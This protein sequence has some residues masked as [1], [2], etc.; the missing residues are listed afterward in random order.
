M[1]LHTQPG[2]YHSA[3]EPRSRYPG[4]ATSRHS[5]HHCVDCESWQEQDR[6]DPGLHNSYHSHG[7]PRQASS[8]SMLPPWH[9]QLV[10]CPALLTRFMLFTMK[11][12]AAR[13]AAY[14]FGIFPQQAEDGAQAALDLAFTCLISKPERMSFS[15]T[16]HGQQCMCIAAPLE[17]PRGIHVQAHC[18]L[19]VLWLTCPLQV[20]KG[21]KPFVWAGL[22]KTAIVGRCYTMYASA[23]AKGKIRK[24]KIADLGMDAVDTAIELDK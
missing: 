20:F 9:F 3:P 12:Q 22:S 15:A 16:Q 19:E 11:R 10:E 18:M 23:L 2:P 1:L 7:S 4:R 24:R 13:E 8:A 14:C 17:R 6:S 5:L 21:S